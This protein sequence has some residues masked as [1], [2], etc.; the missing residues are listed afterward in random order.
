MVPF[1]HEV[2]FYSV[3]DE[4]DVDND[5][6]MMWIPEGIEASEPTKWFRQLNEISPE[7]FGCKCK[8]YYHKNHHQ[9]SSHALDAFN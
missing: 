7:P 9:N 6:Q 8:C 1:M 5:K 2:K 3:D 4:K